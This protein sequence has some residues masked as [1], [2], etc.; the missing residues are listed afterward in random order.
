MAGNGCKWFEWLELAVNGWIL[1][2]MAGNGQNDWTFLD[3][4]ENGWNS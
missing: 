4:A 1:L 3:M 2:D